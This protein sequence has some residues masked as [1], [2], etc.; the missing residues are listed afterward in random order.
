MVCWLELED[1]SEEDKMNW[2]K[3]NNWSW[4]SYIWVKE[5]YEEECSE[6]ISDKSE[7]C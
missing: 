4:S 5:K 6:A 2:L 7:L 3:D 1:L